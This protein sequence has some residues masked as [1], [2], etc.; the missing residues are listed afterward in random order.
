MRALSLF[1]TLALFSVGLAAAACGSTD[2]G[3]N[4]ETSDAGEAGTPHV[5]SGVVLDAGGGYPAF[6]PPSP[7]QVQSYGGNVLKSPKI[8]PVFFSKED[9]TTVAAVT[10]FVAKVGPTKYW[11]AVNT[12]YG[13]GAASSGTPVKLDAWDDPP[14]TIDDTDIQA[15][16]AA[17][18]NGNDPAF[19]TPDD[20]SLYA[21]FYPAGITITLGG[22]PQVGD[23]G[24]P[25]A[26]DDAGDD[27]GVDE[28]GID[29]GVDSGDAGRGPRVS[30]SCQSFGGY[31]GNI[32][33]DSAHGLKQVAY[34]VMPRCATFGN[35]SG[36]DA[37]TG[38]ASHEFVEAATDP[39]PNTPMP[40]YASVDDAHIYW[41][42][43]LGGGEVGDMCAQ[44]ET[45]FVKFPELPLY[46][47]Q[48]SWSNKAA[49]AGHDPCQPPV[50]GSV[51]FNT[52]PV[53]KS[54]VPYSIGGQTVN[55]KG[56]Q[57]PVGM[58]A[59]VEL[60]AW[61]DAPTSGPWTINATDT[62][63][64]AGGTPVLK[65]AFDKTL[66]SNGDKVKMTI[67]AVTAGRRNRQTFIVESKLGSRT[68]V[69]LGVVTN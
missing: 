10:D 20:N 51:Y 68:N 3:G 62:T 27:A 23:G 26:G 34:A 48:R 33:L 56:V 30:K 61:S 35:L 41:Q 31:H 60:D 58:S 29:A 49:K 22:T 24:A 18:L 43:F 63:A 14:T 39:Y 19:G 55:V 4:G 59:V 46:T 37:L 47:V 11:A 44:D 9:A 13:V 69:W 28:A 25:D 66:V 40:G 53:F 16:L 7:P 1:A 54:D 21:L 5:D 36:L 17:K 64:L 65:F 52:A 2:G 6:P 32:Q 42:T 38:T 12:E 67:T 8:T 57:I 50:A 15:W 45:N